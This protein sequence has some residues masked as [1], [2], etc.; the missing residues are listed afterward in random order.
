MEFTKP[1]GPPQRRCL[2]PFFGTFST[3]AE[4][5]ATTLDPSPVDSLTT[6]SSGGSNFGVDDV[7]DTPREDSATLEPLDSGST[8]DEIFDQYFMQSPARE[9]AAWADSQQ[10]RQDYPNPLT[11]K[12]QTVNYHSPDMRRAN[13][14]ID[15]SKHT[16]ALYH[17][18]G[19]SPQTSLPELSQA[20]RETKRAVV[21]SGKGPLHFNRLMPSLYPGEDARA[22]DSSTGSCPSDPAPST[23]NQIGQKPGQ[24]ARPLPQ[25]PRRVH[26]IL[27]DPACHEGDASQAG[28][29]NA[30]V[31]TDSDEDPFK[32]DRGSFGIFL[33]PSREREVSAALRCVSI[34]SMASASG[35]FHSSP[36]EP[37]T[38]RVT[39]S[40]NPFVNRLQHYQAPTLDYDWDDEDR[41]S[42]VKISVRCPRAPPPSPA[43]PPM[44]LSE[45]IQ[46]SQRRRRDINT[47]L[48]DGADWETVV[49]SLGQFDS[50]RAFA[51]SLGLS[52]SH[53]VKVTG[54]SIADYSDTSSVHGTQ[55]E[56]FSSRERIIQ[57]PATNDMPH[58]RY[59]RTLRDTDRPVFLAKPRIH[60]VNGYLHNSNRIFTDPTTGSSASSAR[61]ALVEKLSASIRSRSARKRARR[62]SWSKSRFESLD[63]LS[64]T[65]SEQRDETNGNRAVGNRGEGAQKGN[66]TDNGL[67]ASPMPREPSAAHL[68]AL[69]P[70]QSCDPHYSMDLA[71]PTLFSFPLISLEEA[72]HRVAVKKENG[73][74]FT[75]LGGTTTRKNSSLDS[76]KATQGTTPCTPYIRK[77][78]PAHP[79]RPTSASI[80][81][82]SEEHRGYSGYSQGMQDHKSQNALLDFSVLPLFP[83]YCADQ[84]AER[85]VLGHDRG[86]SNVTSYKSGTPLVMGRHSALSRNFQNPF[87]PVGTSIH[88]KR[89]FPCMP[90]TVF[91]SPP[92]LV[93]RDKREG[94]RTAAAM[95]NDLRQIAAMES[96]TSAF[97]ILNGDGYLSWEARKRRQG[98]YYLM[99]ILCIFPFIAPL[100]YRGTFDSALSWYTRGEAASLTQRQRRNVL[101]IG[102]TISGVWLCALAVFATAM[103]NRNQQM[104]D[105]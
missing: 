16:T 45:F 52:G 49:T 88:S 42:E 94:T 32:Y 20:Q 28:I 74:D 68:R 57:H 54:S 33:R 31:S 91:G 35:V 92:C 65:D 69:R 104:H 8:V 9:E 34:D 27:K 38:P 26:K 37:A 15:L 3:G 53:P 11:F 79:R 10:G 59:G 62:Q 82:I 21:G 24:R 95:A 77:P 22:P 39:Q 56:A 51:S 80:M 97:G 99:C 103:V 75:I 63:S 1:S 67:L 13:T 83:V 18:T 96:G 60:R 36:P 23:N 61:S 100:V 19:D 93:A 43:D 71:S 73:E 64:S 70:T 29:S 30:C 86:I 85:I 81:G 105:A 7:H 17:P 12:A 44:G 6:P 5:R 89:P 87:E 98:Y 66:G 84:T 58:G 40:N 2:T 76:S 46:G 14:G 50:N 47:L 4:C 25:P 72:A 90:T 102:I 48:S 78:V 101:I 55:A 41:P